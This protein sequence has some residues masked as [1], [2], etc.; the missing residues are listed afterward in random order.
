M[1][2]LNC[3]R[4]E[5]ATWI[6]IKTYWVSKGLLVLPRQRITAIRTKASLQ[7]VRNAAA[8]STPAASHHGETDLGKG[9]KRTK[10]ARQAEAVLLIV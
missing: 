5:Y 9:M 2:V 8:T 10:R 4:R 6:C 3:V 1:P 7:F